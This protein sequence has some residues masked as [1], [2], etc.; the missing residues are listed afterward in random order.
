MVCMVLDPAVYLVG[1]WFLFYIQQIA[2]SGGEMW[3]YFG[4]VAVYC[5]AFY[6]LY[7]RFVWIPFGCFAI[8]GIDHLTLSPF[9]IG[10]GL[11][12]I[13][14]FDFDGLLHVLGYNND[15][16]HIFRYRNTCVYSTRQHTSDGKL[17]TV[18][19]S[20]TFTVRDEIKSVCHAFTMFRLKEMLASTQMLADMSNND[21]FNR[22]EVWT[23][24][25]RTAMR[26]QYSELGCVL[27]N[28]SVLE[29]NLS[30]HSSL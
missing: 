9:V 14:V 11:H 15:K 30:H 8:N 13:S 5:V 20:V 26:E 3:C 16:Q 18:R 6:F 7:K 2:C 23:E 4:T 17:Y 29:I 24:N 21:V 12:Y 28:L 10:H 1:A 19:V 25:A 27:N 22:Q